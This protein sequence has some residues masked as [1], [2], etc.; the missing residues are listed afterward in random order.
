MTDLRIIPLR[1][2]CSAI[3]K[4]KGLCK[5]SGTIL[6]NGKHMCWLHKRKADGTII[7]KN[8]DD[9]N[10]IKIDSKNDECSICYNLLN[11]P[12]NIVITNC[13][14]IFHLDC[15]KK[16]QETQ[17]EYRKTCPMCRKRMTMMRS[18]N[19]KKKVIMTNM[20]VKVKICCSM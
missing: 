11:S 5:N 7:Q 4:N 6:H 17:M 3:T 16:W 12:E 19:K 8:K 1:H 14:H 15:I 18:S 13:S 10:L 9:V 2:N 20:D